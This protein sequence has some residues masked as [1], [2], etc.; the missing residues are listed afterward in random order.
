MI[1]KYIVFLSKIHTH[2]HTQIYIY[3]YI[4]THGALTSFRQKTLRSKLAIYT[5]LVLTKKKSSSTILNH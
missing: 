3:I 1:E 5:H 2:T 4:H